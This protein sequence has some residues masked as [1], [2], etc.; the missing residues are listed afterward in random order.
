MNLGEN[1]Y[2]LRTERSM[3]QGD[4]ANALDVSRQ[5]VSKWENNS[6]VPE[7]EKLIRMCD[8][9]DVSMDELIGR[10]ASDQKTG[11]S[12]VEPIPT[13]QQVIIQTQHRPISIRKVLGVILVCLG[14][15][16]LPYA[17]SATHYTPMVNCL[18]LSGSFTLC[19][20]SILLVRYPYIPCGWTLLAAFALHVFL[21]YHWES[22]F[23]SLTLIGLALV[24]M[25]LWTVYAH[26]NGILLI[27]NWLWWAGGITLAALLILFCMNF[28]P[29]F[30]IS[31][32]EYF[33][34]QG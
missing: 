20:I 17:L 2:R 33:A 4:L 8:V 26:R 15:I 3:S 32:T 9:F 14:L 29:P 19:G 10:S 6:A 27:P 31:S 23:L 34:T 1:I 12:T 16:F 28:F 13:V 18:I 21:L 7:L 30:W 11:S 24:G 5:S 22:D 25:I